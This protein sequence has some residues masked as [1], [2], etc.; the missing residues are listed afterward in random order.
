MTLLEELE[1]ITVDVERDVILARVSGSLISLRY[2]VEFL[3]YMGVWDE[4]AAYEDEAIVGWSDFRGENLKYCVGLPESRD[5]FL[6]GI[7]KVCKFEYPTAN[8]WNEDGDDPIDPAKSCWGSTMFAGGEAGGFLG[9]VSDLKWVLS[10]A[11]T[12]PEGDGD[13]EGWIK[14]TYEGCDV[15]VER[16]ENPEDVW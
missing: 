14:K 10:L 5:R 16:I 9:T 6:R 3:R 1:R 2:G 11:M 13:Y 7:A 15:S 8:V 12:T 4:I